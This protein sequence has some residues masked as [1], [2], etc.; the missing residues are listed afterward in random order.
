[1]SDKSSNKNW[2]MFFT[3]CI[4][5]FTA[6]LSPVASAIS[7]DQNKP[8]NIEAG[9]V[10]IKEKQGLAYYS[11]NVKITQGS[12]IIAGKTLTIFSEKDEVV[13]IIIKGQPAS[14]SQLNDEGDKTVAQAKQMT[15]HVK[16]EIL[17][18]QDNAILQQ[19][20]NVFR[21]EKI[22][23]NTAKDIMMA[24]DKNAPSEE[25]IKITIHPKK[26]AEKNSKRS[27]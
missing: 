11:G 20:D 18:L 13:K 4:C 3:L 25:R 7:S 19:K 21:S 23:Y 15:F 6:S 16:K 1:M 10:V 5:F 14:F 12:R 8:I 27:Q 26:D 2:S 17:L 22:S 24:G 9:K